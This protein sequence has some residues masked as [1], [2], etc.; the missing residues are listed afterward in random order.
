MLNLIL[1]GPP[2]S[3]KGTQAALL[4]DKYGFLHIST[5]DLFRSEIG[6]QTDLGLLAQ[7]YMAQ[8]KLVP[9]TVTIDMLRKKVEANPEVTGIIFD[10]F[11][12]TIRQA[13]ALD[14]LLAE[15][16]SEVT[17][18]LALTV[19]EDE[20]VQRILNRAKTSGRSDDA[21]EGIIRDRIAV[22]ENTTTPVF[23]YY[24]ESGKSFRVKGM[25]SIDEIFA[26][27]SAIIDH[28][29]TAAQKL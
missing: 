28:I 11:P 14:A 3:G 29:H 25:G 20:I 26:R 18:L 4:V 22:Y 19:D 16:S 21:D 7:S 17:A 5:G 24:E 13:Q 12:R 23:D 10:G 1:F 2:G 27:L 6:N 9:D 15:R 8:G